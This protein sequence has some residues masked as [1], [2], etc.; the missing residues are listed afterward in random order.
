[1]QSRLCFH[2]VHID[3]WYWVAKSRMFGSALGV[4]FFRAFGFLGA[5]GGV[6]STCVVV[7]TSGVDGVCT[8][9]KRSRLSISSSLELR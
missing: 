9:V 3:F 1:M 6:S 2:E 4:S 8:S 7:T 5:G